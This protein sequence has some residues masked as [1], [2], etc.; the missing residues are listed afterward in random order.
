MGAKVN[1]GNG[2]FWGF[3]ADYRRFRPTAIDTIACPLCLT[4]YRL[5][6]ID[7]LSREHIVPSKLGGA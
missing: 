2:L 6:D 7:D 1:K 5:A 3:A 4:E